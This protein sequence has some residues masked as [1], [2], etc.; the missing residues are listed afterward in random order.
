M[1]KAIRF[2]YFVPVLIPANEALRAEMAEVEAE[3]LDAPTWDMIS[4]LD[5]IETHAETRWHYDLGGELAELEPGSIITRNV[6][7]KGFQ[8]SKLRETNIPAIKRLGEIKRDIMLEDD[9][10]IGE[11]VTC[12]YDR[13]LGMLAVQSN[14]YG[15]TTNQIEELLTNFRLS[16]FN[17][18]NNNQETENPQIVKLR[19]ILDVNGMNAALE[20][21]VIR[22]IKLRATDFMGDN[23]LDNEPL[24]GSARRCLGTFAAASVEITISVGQSRTETLDVESARRAIRLF[25][26]YRCENPNAFNCE[27]TKKDTIDTAVDTI[28]LITPRMT[29]IV[30]ADIE[31]RTS[32]AHGYLFQ[33]IYEKFDNRRGVFAQL[34]TRSEG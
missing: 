24:L 4:W 10:Y 31:P 22:K 11:F 2:N 23:G 5:Y 9:E 26:D 29:D 20:A 8:L 25:N 18:V 32:I 21:E 12:L 1:R 7:T 17:R 15:L 27:V 3:F 19:P 30:S 13:G 34:L 6:S 28:N 16:Y 33:L 14:R